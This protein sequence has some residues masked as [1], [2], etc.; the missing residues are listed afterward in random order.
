MAGN[1]TPVQHVR[2]L[3]ELQDTVT[4]RPCANATVL[5]LC[6]LRPFLA[7]GCNAVLNPVGAVLRTALGLCFTLQIDAQRVKGLVDADAQFAASDRDVLGEDFPG[8]EDLLE[9]QKVV[10]FPVEDKL[11]ARGYAGT[12]DRRFH[13]LRPILHLWRMAGVVK[14]WYQANVAQLLQDEN[15]QFGNHS[16][17]SPHALEHGGIGNPQNL[18]RYF[19]LD[20]RPFHKPLLQHLIQFF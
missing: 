13:E 16:S 4:P 14:E 12:H 20:H 5:P 11:L 6:Q 1:R 8:L 15:L 3:Y 2:Q 10:N 17:R 9:G 19:F 7:D 18:L